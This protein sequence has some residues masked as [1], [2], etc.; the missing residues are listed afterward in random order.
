MRQSVTIPRRCSGWTLIELLITIIIVAVLTA[1]VLVLYRQAENAANTT[2]AEDL[3]TSIQAD[4]H[5]LYADRDSYTGLSGNILRDASPGLT[6]RDPWGGTIHIRST[7][8][9][10]HFTIS[11][12]QV[13]RSACVR[14]GSLN[15][16]DDWSSLQI[17]GVTIQQ[18]DGSINPQSLAAAC[19]QASQNTITWVSP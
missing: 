3:L 13:P 8:G 17:G 15:T 5:Q 9:G 2:R 14:I 18:S 16:G 1:G 4:V 12:T 6:A 11:F 19:Q 7:S 10:H